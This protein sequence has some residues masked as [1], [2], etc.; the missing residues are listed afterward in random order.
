MD[1]SASADR[2]RGPVSGAS[3]PLTRREALRL[4]ALTGAIALLAGPAAAAR[5]RTAHRRM[6]ARARRRTGARR[7]VRGPRRTRARG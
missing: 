2:F 3:F 7:R 5:R 4:G 1:A 6:A